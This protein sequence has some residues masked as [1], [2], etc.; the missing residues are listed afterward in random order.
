LPVDEL[1]DHFTKRLRFSEEEAREV[2]K[3][4]VDH[5]W[6]G[7]MAFPDNV[8]RP[9]R[10]VMATQLRVS[11]ESIVVATADGGYRR[12]TVREMASCMGFPITYQFWGRTETIRGKLVGNAVAPGVA[13]A[14][15]RE[16]IAAEGGPVP[17]RPSVTTVVTWPAPRPIEAAA[18][19]RKLRPSRK[20]REH[21]PG[22]KLPGYRVDLDNLGTKR[23]HH[24]VEWR[25]VLYR[26]GGKSVRHETVALAEAL[27]YFRECVGERATSQFIRTV[28][29]ELGSIPNATTL[30]RIRAEQ[31]RGEITPFGVLERIG[32]AVAQHFGSED[33]AKK[34]G[35]PMP[36]RIAATL[37]ATAYACAVA[38]GRSHELKA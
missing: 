36:P 23:G 31:I 18:R 25:A 37:V 29:R 35:G 9:A 21:I 38:N 6:Y 19:P 5:S 27:G 8:D 14:I 7:K 1:T 17:I 2:R 26:G 15:A 34:N 32:S 4:K 3:S 16:I 13:Y 12:L 33:A 28:T 30:Q 22:S 11:R 10:T 20:F 24:L